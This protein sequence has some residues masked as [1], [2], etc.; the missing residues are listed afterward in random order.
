MNRKLI[1]K[2]I[3][4]D[5]DFVNNLRATIP[6]RVLNF[7]QENIKRDFPDREL[8]RMLKNTRGFKESLKE[9]ET[10]PRKISKKW[11]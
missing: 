9:M 11:S 1:D 7:P 3:R 10:L 8:T 2:E 5:P 6:K 4:A